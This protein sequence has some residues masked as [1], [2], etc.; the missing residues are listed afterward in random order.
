MRFINVNNG[1]A[2]RRFAVLTASA[3]LLAF[4]LAACSSDDAGPGTPFTQALAKNYTDLATQASALP[5]PA[6]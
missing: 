5:P 4:G 1:I 2:A 3:A 6:G